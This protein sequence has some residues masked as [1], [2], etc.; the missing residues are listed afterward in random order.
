MLALSSHVVGDGSGEQGCV[1]QVDELGRGGF[2]GVSECS[3]GCISFRVRYC[4]CK[5]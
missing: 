1:F 4:G 3:S 2:L 5:G